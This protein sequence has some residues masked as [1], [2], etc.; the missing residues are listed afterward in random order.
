MEPGEVPDVANL[1]FKRA[2]G[3]KPV[4]MTKPY[5]MELGEL[6]VWLVEAGERRHA[7]A[8]C[9]KPKALIPKTLR[10]DSR[11][12]ISLKLRFCFMR[13]EEDSRHAIGYTLTDGFFST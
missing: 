6:A 11:R 3:R 9:L 7:V 4:A 8:A 5:P 13:R 1:W 12:G 2:T 10:S